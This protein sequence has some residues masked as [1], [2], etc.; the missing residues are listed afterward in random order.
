LKREN[1]RRAKAGFAR[2]SRSKLGLIVE[3]LIEITDGQ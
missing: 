3:R 1:E 2:Q